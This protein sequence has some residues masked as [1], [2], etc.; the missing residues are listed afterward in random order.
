MLLVTFCTPK[1]SGLAKLAKSPI[2][3]ISTQSTTPTPENHVPVLAYYYIWFDTQSWDRAKS[4]YPLLGQFSSDDED[5]MRQHVEWAK[6]AGIDGFIVSWKSTE[7][8]NRR[9]D[10][11]VEIA[12]EENFK[13][14]IIL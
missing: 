8:L 3:P 7:K 10:Q 5:V 13:L 12:E 1:P 14:A 9:L 2:A 6:D 4:D 11:L